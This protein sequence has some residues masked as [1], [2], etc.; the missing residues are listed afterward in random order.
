MQYAGTDGFGYHSQPISI[1]SPYVDGV[2]TTYGNPQQ[3]V[4][5][6]ASAFAEDNPNP[7]THFP[8]DSFSSVTRPWGRPTVGWRGVCSEQLLCLQLTSV[9]LC[10]TTCPHH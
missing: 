5:S 7:G 4:W 6:F 2:S 10:G 1:D 8:C 9:V 3:H